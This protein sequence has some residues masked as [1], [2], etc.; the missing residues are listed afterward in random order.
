MQQTVNNLHQ[1]SSAT[2]L[3]HQILWMKKWDRCSVCS[4]AAMVEMSFICTGAQC[5]VQWE[6][7]TICNCCVIWVAKWWTGKFEAQSNM[8][9][10]QAVALFLKIGSCWCLWL[11]TNSFSFFHWSKPFLFNKRSEGRFT[12]VN[13]DLS[14]LLTSNGQNG[15]TSFICTFLSTV[16]WCPLRPLLTSHLA[17]ALYQ[18]PFL[19]SWTF[20]WSCYNKLFL[21]VDQLPF[22]PFLGASLFQKN[23]TTWAILRHPMTHLATSFFTWKRRIF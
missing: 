20:C 19:P 22:L 23:G 15:D 4:I 3:C 13:N 9:D 14:L 5:S 7:W 16:Q 2:N 8:P 11:S 10:V 12:I 1:L 21:A 17:L 18:L 6:M